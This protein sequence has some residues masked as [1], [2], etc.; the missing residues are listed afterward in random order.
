MIKVLIADNQTLTYEGLL[1]ILSGIKGVKVIGRA[2]DC[3]DLDVLIQLKPDIIII[4][5][6]QGDDFEVQF[7]QGNFI[8]FNHAHIL[9][10][11]NK[12]V[13]NNIIALSDMGIKNYVSKNCTRDE[14]LQ[15]VSSTATGEQFFCETTMHTIFGKNLPSKK[16]DASSI[17]SPREVEIVNLIADGLHNK[18][19]AERLYLSVH[20]IKTHRKNIIK[21][22][23]FTFKNAAELVLL[24]NY[25]N[26]VFI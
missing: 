4:D 15:A 9:I 25:I 12:Q 11:S 20:T 19:I 1:S 7:E 23:G 18:D 10:L 5:H 24:I 3:K 21:K 14:L 17:L 26:E 2:V 22:L 8:K 6:N 13:R 16:T